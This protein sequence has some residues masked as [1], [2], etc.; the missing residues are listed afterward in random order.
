MQGSCFVTIYD[1]NQ[2]TYS[3]WGSWETDGK[4]LLTNI[5][6][7]TQN[8]KTNSW[9]D[10]E[11]VTKQVLN[12]LKQYRIDI[13]LIQP[14]EYWVET[15]PTKINNEHG[16]VYYDETQKQIGA[17][18]LPSVWDSITNT[19]QFVDGLTKKSGLHKNQK[20]FKLYQ[21]ESITWQMEF[22]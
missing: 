18:Y 6:K 20:G 7:A 19:D 12:D 8:V 17:T 21:Y 15:T 9:H 5:K 11:P 16:Y 3:C 4:N 10:N 1:G 13:T 22:P 14:I 2:D